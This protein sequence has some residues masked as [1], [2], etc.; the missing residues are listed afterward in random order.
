MKL[1]LLMSLGIA[2]LFPQSKAQKAHVHG[3]AELNIALEGTKGE[4]EF[5]APAAGVVGFEHEAKTPAQKKA[6]SDA[7]T[8]LRTRGNELVIFPA[9][10]GCKM[11]PKEVEVHREGPQHSEIHAHYDLNCLKAP[12]GAIGFGVSKMFPRTVEVK[13]QFVSD[14]LQ[15]S[16]IVI[17][18]AAKLIL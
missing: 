7:L 13:V 17:R 6:V 12:S 11:S 16:V 5:E 10:A 14:K 8:A 3:S 2:I 9:A 4:V 15:K 1:L 18:D